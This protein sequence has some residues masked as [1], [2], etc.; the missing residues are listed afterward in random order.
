MFD[1]D[2]SGSISKEELRAVFETAEQKDDE[3]WNEI[4]SEVDVNGDGEIS[5]DE[6]KT[7]MH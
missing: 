1:K 3:L 6:F 4:F 7:C 5:F 2:Q